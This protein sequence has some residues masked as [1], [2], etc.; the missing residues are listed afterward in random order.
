MSRRISD[1]RDDASLSP[2]ELRE[3]SQLRVWHSEHRC[4]QLMAHLDASTAT[5]SLP[6]P[7]IQLKPA[8]QN[9]Y[10]YSF[11]QLV[12]NEPRD[13][14]ILKLVPETPYE[15]AFEAQHLLSTMR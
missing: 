10:A 8:P 7:R 6:P 1:E 3:V 9:A 15:C 11:S 2:A 13:K 5:Q 4:A 14:V 12:G